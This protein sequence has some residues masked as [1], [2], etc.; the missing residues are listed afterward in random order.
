MKSNAGLADRVIR[1]YFGMVIAGSFIFYN[2][3]WALLGVPVFVTGIVG[4]C[5][6]YSLLRINT[7][8]KEDAGS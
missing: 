4:Y 5:P 2:S 8:E 6:L 1:M 7:F 3:A